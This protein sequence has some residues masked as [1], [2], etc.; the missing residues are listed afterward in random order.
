MF[1]IENPGLYSAYEAYRTSLSPISASSR[2][3]ETLLSAERFPLSHTHLGKS[4]AA[5]CELSHRF[6]KYY[7]KPAWD[8]EYS[9]TRYGIT[10][11]APEVVIKKTFC[12]LLH[13]KKNRN[14][15]KEKLLIIAP[16]SGH[17]STLLRGTVEGMLPHFDVYI[18]EW[19]NPRDVPVFDGGFSLSDHVDYLMDFM[20]FFEGDVTALAVCQPVVSTMVAAAYMSYKQDK[21]LPKNI[22]VMGG[23]IDARERPT[24]VNDFAIDR[25]LLWFSSQLIT[26]VPLI[27]AGAMRRVYPGFLQLNGFM[28]MN[29]T[30]HTG[31]HIELFKALIKGDGDGADKH[32]KFYDEYLAVMDLPAE[33]F[34]Q[35]IDEVFHKYSLP[36]GQMVHLGIPIKLENIRNTRILAVEGELDDISG[37]GQTKA[38]L[39]LCSGL[40]EKDKHY[41]LQKGVGHYGIFNGRNFKQ[42]IVPVVTDFVGRGRTAKY[43]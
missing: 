33:F 3:I 22:V 20:R 18:T 26:R 12:N 32:K 17:Y 24:K 41:H 7:V 42:H 23:P 34:L 21:G 38:G 13:F 19:I 36:K 8:I 1:N 14:H 28:S 35:T 4:L 6:T 27:Y 31:S 10:E 11:V 2:A 16:L 29:M 5:S 43:N 25:S 40:T 37:I 30:R 15:T 9:K 39:K